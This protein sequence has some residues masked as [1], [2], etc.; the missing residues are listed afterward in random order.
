[1][2]AMRREQAVS[3]GVVIL[4]HGAALWLLLHAHGATQVSAPT[5]ALATFEVRVPPPPAPLPPRRTA[6]AARR[7]GQPGR[8][9]VKA[10]R[11]AVAA[12]IPVVVPPL[13]PLAPLTPQSG[14]AILGGAVANGT[15]PG[16]GQSGVG[17]GSGGT[18]DG[19]GGGSRARWLSGTIG[20]RDYPKAE[21]S[22]RIGG[23]VTV[24][25]TVA[26][27][28]HARACAVVRSSGNPT[29]DATTCRLVEARFR[30]APARDA[31]GSPV[32]ERRGWR[33]R[34]WIERD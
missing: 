34:W 11:N 1:M 33:Q 6:H 26:A 16:A 22:A 24:A 31:A 4:L 18:G 12:P 10:E 17:A 7:A 21:R 2:R 5:N 8:S 25:F 9:G 27:D 23:E 14:T 13:S 15:G 29:L 19:V 30:Y 20:P 32:S 3:A 28:G